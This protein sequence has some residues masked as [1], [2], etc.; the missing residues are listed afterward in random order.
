VADRPP[1]VDGSD[2]PSPRPSDFPVPHPQ[3]ARRGRHGACSPPRISARSISSSWKCSR[4]TRSTNALA[5]ASADDRGDRLRRAD[6]ESARRRPCQGHHS[7]RYQAGEYL[8]HL[9]PAREDR[10]LRAGESRSASCRSGRTGGIDQAP[11]NHSTA[12]PDRDV[13]SLVKRSFAT[14]GWPSFARPMVKN[15]LNAEAGVHPAGSPAL[16]NASNPLANVL[17][18]GDFDRTA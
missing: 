9:C 1:A 4:V 5:A 10:R 2:A 11:S 8:R 18:C 14:G 3:L 7:S 15:R 13:A 16:L 6:C 12:D 17:P